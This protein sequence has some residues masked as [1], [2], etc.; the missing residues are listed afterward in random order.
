MIFLHTADLDSWLYVHRTTYFGTATLKSLRVMIYIE[1]PLN[2]FSTFAY[3][4][5]GVHIGAGA[6]LDTYGLSMLLAYPS[7]EEMISTG[8]H[9]LTN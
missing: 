7:G 9:M 4:V 3:T 2:M 5:G 8:R 1:G 6:L